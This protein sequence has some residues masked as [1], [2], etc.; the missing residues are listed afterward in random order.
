MS[1]GRN[2]QLSPGE[3]A[4]IVLS[5]APGEDT[6]FRSSKPDLGAVAAP[7]AFGG[8]DAFDLLKLQAAP[9][10]KASADISPPPAWQHS[11]MTSVPPP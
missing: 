7:F 10:L 2:I 11:P 6:M 1:A 3:R 8:E 4:E 5:L 9:V